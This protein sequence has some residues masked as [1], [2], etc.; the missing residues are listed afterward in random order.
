M[1]YVVKT[2]AQ[3]YCRGQSHLRGVGLR[4]SFF[5]GRASAR[6]GAGPLW[7]NSYLVATVGGPTLEVVKRHVESQR[8]TW[9]TLLPHDG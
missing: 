6:P 9:A 2:A 5:E 7:A 3:T 8:N 1:S 4:L